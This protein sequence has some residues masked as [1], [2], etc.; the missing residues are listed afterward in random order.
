VSGTIAGVCLTLAASS[1]FSGVGV[2][3]EDTNEVCAKVGYE[4]KFAGGIYEGLMRMGN[5]LA[6]VRALLC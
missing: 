2:D 3:P 5:I 4:D 6:G 1:Q